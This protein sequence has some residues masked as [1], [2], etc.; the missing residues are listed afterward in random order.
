MNGLCGAWT[1]EKVINSVAATSS[2]ERSATRCDSS[3]NGP[4]I[5][6]M[7]THEAKNTGTIET[8]AKIANGSLANQ[9]E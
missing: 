1:D 7:V 4:G 8:T 6:K 2:P 5:S 9:Q 3:F